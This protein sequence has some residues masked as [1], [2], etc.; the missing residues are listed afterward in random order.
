MRSADP[1]NR[2][3]IAAAVAAGARLSAK[4][5][6]DTN[7]HAAR[8]L[9]KR[10]RSLAL[11]YRRRRPGLAAAIRA[12]AKTVGRDLAPARDRHVLG[13]TAGAFGLREDAA[14]PPEDDAMVRV[15]ETARLLLIARLAE[16][17]PKP[18]P[19]D[20]R[21]AAG[22]AVQRAS[23][24]FAAVDRRASVPALHHWR[25]RLKDVVYLLEAGDTGIASA[26]ALHRRAKEAAELLGEDRDLAAF[27]ASLRS[28]KPAGGVEKARAAARK[29]REGL[30]AQAIA[31]G[32]EME[33]IAE[34]SGIG[35]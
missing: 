13:R 21:R 22:R 35:R 4:G 24:A 29:A 12:L 2:Q 15:D 25:K 7:V 26:R 16:S 30:H 1:V 27:I 3:V 23:T 28:A 33:K 9:L 17:L 31:L 10:I 20:V 11:A 19:K 8:I 34:R 6:A 5:D 14:R 32:R 18:R